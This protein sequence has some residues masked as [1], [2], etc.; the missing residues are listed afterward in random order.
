MSMLYLIFSIFLLCSKSSF[1]QIT[2]NGSIYDHESSGALKNCKLIFFDGQRYI[3]KSRTDAYGNFSKSFQNCNSINLKIFSDE[4]AIHE[5]LNIPTD[6]A[7]ISLHVGLRFRTPT[8]DH[9]QK[10]SVS[11]IFVPS[12][13]EPVIRRA[14]NLA[15]LDKLQISILQDAYE[16]SKIELSNKGPIPFLEDSKRATH[17]NQQF[18]AMEKENEKFP[19]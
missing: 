12:M 1:A 7:E 15:K 8:K 9:N 4:F 6:E 11:M 10:E 5:I 13:K 18:R 16:Y 17:Y 19:Y 3:G 14:Q 2:I